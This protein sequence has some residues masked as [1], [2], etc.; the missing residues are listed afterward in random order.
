M[1]PRLRISIITGVSAVLAVWLGWQL[2]CGNFL[3]AAIVGAVACAA[4]VRLATGFTIDVVLLGLVLAGYI[5][6]NRGFAQFILVPGLP[7]FP[8]E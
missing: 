1:N 3:L 4:L 5:V 7:L 2:A 6:G 8:A